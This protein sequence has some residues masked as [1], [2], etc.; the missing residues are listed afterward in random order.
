MTDLIRRADAV[1]AMR[2][3]LG[4]EF[5]ERAEIE[6][7]CLTGYVP[8]A[9]AV[10]VVRC[11]DCKYWNEGE[12]YNTCDRHIGNGYPSNYFCADGERRE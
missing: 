10:E 1:K 8:A 9:E 5:G 3:L 12:W 6:L 2:K 4:E 11:K 7:N